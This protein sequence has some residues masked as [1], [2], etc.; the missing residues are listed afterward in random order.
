MDTANDHSLRPTLTA[1]KQLA[2]RTGV[3]VLVIRHMNKRNGESAL[4]RGGGSVAFVAAARSALIVGHCP[5]DPDTR[6]LASVKLNV[7]RQP[8]AVAFRIGTR[9]GQPVV[10]S[11]DEQPYVIVVRRGDREYREPFPMIRD[12]SESRHYDMAHAPLRACPP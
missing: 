12:T 9:D 5:D 1:L 3:A 11:G 6:V 4:Y 7:G 8:S 2:E 10:V